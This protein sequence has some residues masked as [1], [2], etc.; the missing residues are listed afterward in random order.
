MVLTKAPV[1]G[2][3]DVLPEEMALRDYTIHLIKETY[4]SFGFRPMETPCMEHIGN[5]TSKQGGENE[6]LI[7][8]VLKRG[9]K[10]SLAEASSPDDLVDNGLRYDLT[11]PLCR[12]YAN[13]LD[14]LPNPFK[15]L[16]IGSVWRADQPQKGRFR[17]FTQCDIDVLGDASMLAEIELMTATTTLLGKLGFSDYTLRLNHRRLL[18]AMAEYAGFPPSS[19]DKV[20]IILD[21]MDKIGLE[22]VARE[23]LSEGLA[24]ESVE[25]YLAFFTQAEGK[26]LLQVCAERLAPA[27]VS[28]ADSATGLGML[29]EESGQAA[30]AAVEE[31]HTIITCMEAVKDTAVQGEFALVF[32]PTL[33]RG[34]G[35]YTGPIFEITV[36]EFGSSVAGGGRYDQLVGNFTSLQ[37]PACGFSI[38]FERIISILTDRGF[39]PPSPE[40][41][42]AFLAEKG[43]S[44][45]ELCAMLSE[46]GKE[47]GTG[48]SV[49]VTPKN[50]NSKFQREQLGKD[51]YT[52][53]RNF[54]RQ[55]E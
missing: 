32:D 47:R 6:N 27:G 42:I 4:K 24:R 41:K 10:L 51:G 50:K 16:Q 9:E 29:A 3:K 38:G 48:A 28:A 40:R 49:L 43:L 2:M 5:L 1:K 13:N 22:G 25:S 55:N 14:K 8:K 54:H 35:Y 20:F 46:A 19:N 31:L 37:A 45:E 30:A 39:Q 18:K 33:V 21:K 23:L 53:F 36:K 44:N 11:L 34:M 52:E 26:D 17:Q 15:A 12:F 7:F